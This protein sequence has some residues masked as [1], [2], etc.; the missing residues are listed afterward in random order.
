VYWAGVVAASPVPLRK[1]RL[2]PPETLVDCTFEVNFPPDG[3]AHMKISWLGIALVVAPLVGW[4]QAQTPI[5]VSGP[6]RV[7]PGDVVQITVFEVDELSQPAVVSQ[8]GSIPLPLVG[9][10]QVGGLTTSEIEAELKSLYSRDLLRNPQISVRV[11][12]FRSQPVSIL[13]AVGEPGVYQLQ[14]R[15]RLL[16]VLAIAAG[17]SPEVGETITISRSG[18]QR[19]VPDEAGLPRSPPPVQFISP[20]PAEDRAGRTEMRV[21]VRDLLSGAA[22]EAGNP[23]IE[24]HDVIQVA[25]AGVV[26][27]LGAVK[28]PGGFPIKDQ[29]KV[30]VLRAISLAAG[31]DG[32]AAPQGARI[33]R[34]LGAEKFEVPVP[35]RDILKGRARDIELETND[36][37][38]IPDSRAK[39]A[40][41]R[42]AEAAIQMATG[43]VIWRR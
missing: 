15:R 10:V 36:I 21:V 35:V 37:L 13:G 1:S 43:L 8:Q 32:H 2:K 3:G 33:I 6:Y 20:Q 14:G 34:Q 16:D 25:K 12:E 38:F 22:G 27:V 30:T 23:L 39:N 42:G 19:P 18:A 40:L 29:E 24:P 26:Y 4:P 9:E 5:G 28:Q 11:E 31:L 41:S 17:L 7:G